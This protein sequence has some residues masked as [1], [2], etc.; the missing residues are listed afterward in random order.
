L[1]AGD[2]VVTDWSWGRRGIRHISLAL[3]VTFVCCS[4]RRRCGRAT[5]RRALVLVDQG[6]GEAAELERLRAAWELARR[7]WLVRLLAVAVRHLGGR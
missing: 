2:S 4:W 1:T 3:P 6:A 5:T 7:P